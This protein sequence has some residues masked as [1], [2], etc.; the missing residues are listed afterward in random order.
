MA[1]Q[2]CNALQGRHLAK[3][4][5]SA[6]LKIKQEGD[7]SSLDGLTLDS[8][9][10]QL[11]QD[12]AAGDTALQTELD[13]TQAGA[14]LYA[15]GSV[16]LGNRHDLD[17]NGDVEQAAFL[18]DWLGQGSVTSLAHGITRLDKTLASY[19]SVF[20]ET[21]TALQ[22][23]LDATQAGA[24][25]DDDGSVDLSERHDTDM[26]PTA[27]LSGYGAGAFAAPVT[28]LAHGITRLDQ[29]VEI[30]ALSI[31]GNDADISNLQTELDATQAGAG[32][33]DDGTYQAPALTHF[34]T[35][36]GSIY[37]ADSTDVKDAA[38]RAASA[39][40]RISYLAGF[41]I[42]GLDTYDANA[43][44]IGQMSDVDDG[45]R[46][47]MGNAG[48][49][50]HADALLDTTIKAHKDILDNVQTELDD[51]QASLGLGT[52]GSLSLAYNT[53]SPDMD[54]TN[55]F[56]IWESE[57]ACDTSARIDTM[58]NFVSINTFN[59]GK[60]AND[61]AAE[62]ARI[63][64]ILDAAG[65]NPDSFA[66][67]VELINSVDTENDD[68]LSTVIGNLNSEIA[69][70]NGEVTALQA[71]DAAATT[72]R[73]AIRTD[74]ATES[75]RIDTMDNFVSINTFNVGK[76]ANDIAAESARIDAY[77]N[78]IDSNFNVEASAG[79]AEL[80]F[81]QG[82]PRMVMTANGSGE[83]TVCFDVKPAE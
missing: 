52:D 34:T 42:D 65:A 14:G 80:H 33:G 40:S 41:S 29:H 50:A 59:V 51:T 38:I 74:I 62:S 58:D 4:E 19:V 12:R 32:L 66:D 30:N 73:A 76:N 64:A 36:D 21:D 27:Y 24:G 3:G 10:E 15:D 70:T 55:Y 23:E 25:L 11:F 69:A 60:N 39:A 28:S 49:L 13:A 31:S 77:D 7:A 47:Y 78:R 35:H 53:S 54:V 63:D 17:S 6:Q 61:I 45:D 67:V 18:G 46:H 26:G 2:D 83:V 20:Q 1:I 57:P 44:W 79:T 56:G 81:G 5:M 75:A 8:A 43:E 22:T 48:S 71:A 9:V 16:Y 68:A 72:D 37:L 82:Q